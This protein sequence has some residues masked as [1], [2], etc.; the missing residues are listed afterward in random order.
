M[1]YSFKEVFFIGLSFVGLST[2]FAGMA[3]AHLGLIGV[4]VAIGFL[5]LTELDV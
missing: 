1:T 2:L 4:G 5:S 3:A